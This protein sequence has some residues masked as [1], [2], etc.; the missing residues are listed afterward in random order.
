MSGQGVVGVR[1]Q[2]VHLA[3]DD[4]EALTGR[5]TFRMYRGGSFENWVRVGKHVVPLVTA[6]PVAEGDT[7]RLILGR[8]RFFAQAE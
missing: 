2:E 4:S 3:P 1:A 5:V 8:V 7:V 6:T